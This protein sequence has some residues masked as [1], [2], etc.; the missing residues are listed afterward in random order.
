[1]NDALHVEGLAGRRRRRPCRILCHEDLAALAMH[2]ETS[3]SV[4]ISNFLD[5]RLQH[6]VRLNA[7]LPSQAW[8]KQ[9]Q[10]WQEA[11]L[12]PAG[13]VAPCETPAACMA[14]ATDFSYER[15]S[16]VQDPGRPEQSYLTRKVIQE[17]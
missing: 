10:A 7:K 13:T 14:E 3:A 17:E 1:M 9:F 16:Q 8:L 12:S 15:R 2:S 4:V 6:S 5:D 11:E